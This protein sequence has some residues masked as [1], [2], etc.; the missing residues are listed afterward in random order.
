MINSNSKKGVFLM[1]RKGKWPFFFFLLRYQNE[2]YQILYT[3]EDFLFSFFLSFF[4]PQ[5]FDIFLGWNLQVQHK[6]LKCFG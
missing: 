6:S 5:K 1:E 2:L 3:S 4:F